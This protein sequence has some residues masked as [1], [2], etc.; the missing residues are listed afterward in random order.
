MADVTA[1]CMLAGVVAIG[2]S[3]SVGAA[4]PVLGFTLLWCGLLW[5]TVRPWL[6]RIKVEKSS[7]GGAMVVLLLLAL[8]SAS[9]TELIGIHA[10]FGAF[11]AGTL[12]AGHHD[13]RK[14]VLERIEPL[15]EALLL[16]LFFASTGLKTQIG[17]LNQQDWLVCA[18]LILLATLG[19]LGGTSLAARLGGSPWRDSLALGFLMNTRGLME[20]IVLNVGYDLGFL[21]ARIFAMLVVMALATT[22]LTGPAL[23]WMQRRQAF[24]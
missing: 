9:V 2:Q 16:P 24:S 13:L 23:A 19:K 8:F 20:I 12:V 10:L 3:A 4:L 17:L 14:L 5:L 1:W 11:F 18:G 21:S 6:Q 7:Q 15:A 22:L